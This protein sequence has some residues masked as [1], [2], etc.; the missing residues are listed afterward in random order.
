MINWIAIELT[1]NSLTENTYPILSAIAL[2]NLS[3]EP[4]AC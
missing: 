4:G 2:A 3:A 1:G